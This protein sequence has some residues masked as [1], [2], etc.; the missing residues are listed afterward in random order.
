MPTLLWAHPGAAF[1]LPR[2]SATPMSRCCSHHGTGQGMREQRGVCVISSSARRIKRSEITSLHEAAQKAP[3]QHGFS[4]EWK[5]KR[6]YFERKLGGAE[7]QQVAR[8]SQ[9]PPSS[10]LNYHVWHFPCPR[11]GQNNSLALDT[12]QLA[13]KISDTIIL[14]WEDSEAAPLFLEINT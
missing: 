2:D 6:P 3:G 12:D 5:W 10:T 4:R 11:K 13:N 1:V 9:H 7:P 8:L 14:P